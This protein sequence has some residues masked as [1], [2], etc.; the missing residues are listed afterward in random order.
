MAIGRA[1]RARPKLIL[2][3]EPLV[4]LDEARKAEILPYFERLRDEVKVPILYVSL[5]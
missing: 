5:V 2:A 3:D 4:A 1:L